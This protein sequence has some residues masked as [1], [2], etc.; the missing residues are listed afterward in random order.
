MKQLDKLNFDKPTLVAFYLGGKIEGLNVE[1]H[2]IR[3]VV[4]VKRDDFLKQIKQAWVG[5]PKSLH[6]D[7]FIPLDYVDGHKIEINDIKVESKKLYFLN[8]GFYN[9]NQFGEA[10]SMH[11]LVAN[12]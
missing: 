10:H 8:L 11:F 4:G 9:K 1:A 3:F 6:I 5:E 7:S 12:P 2:D